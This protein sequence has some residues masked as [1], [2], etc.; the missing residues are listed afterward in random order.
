MTSEDGATGAGRVRVVVDMTF[1]D[2]NQGGSGVYARSLLGAFRG[3]QDVEV[4]EIRSRRPGAGRTAWWLS[5]GAAARV[6]RLP[7]DVVHC[8]NF[9]SPWRL[10]V[11][12]VVTVFDLSTRRF[13]EDH[14]LEWRGYERLLLPA[15]LR[16][17]DR[18]IA[19]SEVTRQD[20]MRDYGVAPD[21]VVTIYPGVDQRFFSPQPPRSRSERP[22]LLFPGAP[23]KRKNIEVVLQAMAGASAGSRLAR[24]DLE[25]TG[26]TAERFPAVAARID[27]LGLKPRVVWRGLLPLDAM[28][29]AVAGAD[30]V[31]YPSLYE[32][33]GFPPLEAMAVGTPVVASTASCLPEVLGDGALL[34]E[35]TD[36]AAWSSAVESVLS[37]NTMATRLVAAGRKR[38][39]SF[40]W[41]RCAD[42]TLQV[43]R[44]V[45]A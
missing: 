45:R 2:R 18:V 42:E 41:K 11:P 29:A 14:P 36:V 43:Y 15:R 8:P 19:I 5:N 31:V 33:F 25:I 10:P 12:L 27:A 35:A 4:S 13:P 26:A 17:A 22:R 37:D 40:T 28:P 32:G 1:P 44:A 16:T 39:A 38:V 3:R 30:V 20:V 6:R 34:V 24:A 7:A 21:R 9:V 23:V